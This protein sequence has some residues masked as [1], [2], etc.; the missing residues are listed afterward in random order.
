MPETAAFLA[1]RLTSEG[2][3]TIAFFD[4]LSDVQ[5]QSTIYTEGATWSIRNV[6]AHFVM[7]EKSF[8][9]LLSNIRDGGPGAPEG[10]DIDR[11]NAGQ[12]REAAT[13][14]PQELLEQFKTTR[15]GMAAWVAD[16]S[17]ADLEKRG[18]HPFLG[19]I[20]LAEM[21]KAVYLHN[22]VH[23]RD[24]RRALPGRIAAKN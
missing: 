7:A 4:S 16:L 9:E 8:M 10:F 18:R 14:S 6:L 15:A 23:T 17:A 1:Q 13:L 20:T 5:W 12:Q 21:I 11:H 22:Q 24:L 19:V 3:K 2:Q